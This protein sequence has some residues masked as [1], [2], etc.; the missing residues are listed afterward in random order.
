MA[1]LLASCTPCPLDVPPIPVSD[2]FPSLP[3]GWMLVALRPEPIKTPVPEV[4]EVPLKV[5]FPHPGVEVDV[6]I[7]AENRIPA[8]EEPEH[9]PVIEIEPSKLVMRVTCPIESTFMLNPGPAPKDVPEIAM[10]P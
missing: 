3:I 1:V 5:I 6:V 10:S 9:C 8:P 7:Y 2:T 4:S